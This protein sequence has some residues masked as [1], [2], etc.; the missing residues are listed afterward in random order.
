MPKSSFGPRASYFWTH[1]GLA[2]LLNDDMPLEDGEAPALSLR[3]EASAEG[4]TYLQVLK[5]W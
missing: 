5:P 4:L 1:V 3:E 2:T